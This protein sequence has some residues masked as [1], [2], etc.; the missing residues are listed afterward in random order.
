[1][2]EEEEAQEEGLQQYNFVRDVVNR[3]VGAVKI[4]DEQLESAKKMN[5]LTGSFF[6]SQIALSMTE[7]DAVKTKE[8]YK[9]NE[10]T[11]INNFYEKLLLLKDLM[12]T[13]KGKELAQER[14]DFMQK[15]LD[16]F[17]KEWNLT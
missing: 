12:N 7:K 17:Y 13:E 9:K 1:M 14:H 16:E 4:F 11:T 5:D 6:K 2:N 15:F 10:G 8:E 3:Y